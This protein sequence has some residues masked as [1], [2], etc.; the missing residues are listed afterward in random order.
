M[1]HS[2]NLHHT[3]YLPDDTIQPERPRA[4]DRKWERERE[5]GKG[6]G[7]ERDGKREGKCKIISGDVLI[8]V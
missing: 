7:R 8:K 3:L 4:R 1:N 6:S 5:M 2:H